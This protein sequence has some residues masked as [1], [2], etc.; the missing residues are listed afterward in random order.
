ML[1]TEDLTEPLMEFDYRLN[2]IIPL[3][4]LLIRLR[5]FINADTVRYNEARFCFTV[6]YQTGVVTSIPITGCGTYSSSSNAISSGINL[7]ERAATASSI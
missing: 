2:Y 3:I 1:S 4:K 5:S 7:I 6:K